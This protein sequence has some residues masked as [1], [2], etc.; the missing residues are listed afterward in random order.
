MDRLENTQRISK[1]IMM[2]NAFT[3][4]A[5]GQDWYENHFEIEFMPDDCYPDYMQ[6]NE[7]IMKEV[8]GREFNIEDAVKAVYEFL[9]VTYSP[10]SLKVVDHIR[11]C[12]THFDVDVVKETI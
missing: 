8:D 7:F 2:P 6:V 4:C 11:N 9:W 12:R 5:I 3:K 10:K 1:I